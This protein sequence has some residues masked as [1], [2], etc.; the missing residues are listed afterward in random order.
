MF[1]LLENYHAV[2]KNVVFF[3]TKKKKRG[4]IQNWEKNSISFTSGFNPIL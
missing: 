4:M 1:S 3:L 2:I